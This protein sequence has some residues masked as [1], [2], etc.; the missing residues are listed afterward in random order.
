MTE[1]RRFQVE[2]IARL[3]NLPPWFLQDLTHANFANSE[4]QDLHLVKHTLA[5]W[6]RAFEQELNLKLFGRRNTSRWVVINMDSLLRGDFKT[7]SEGIARLIQVGAMK[8]KDG[9]KYVGGLDDN[10]DPAA[11]KF[12][13]QG[14]MVP[15]GAEPKPTQNSGTPPPA[16]GGTN[17]DGA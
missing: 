7:R 15:L 5:H 16:N 13:M 14:A 2:E 9:T 17:D 10:T 4:N 3:Y 8:P 11:D 1:A 6:V 12:Y